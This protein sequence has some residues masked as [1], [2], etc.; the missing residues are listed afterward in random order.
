M[1][2]TKCHWNNGYYKKPWLLNY[3]AVSSISI[4][5]NISIIIIKRAEWKSLGLAK[6]QKYECSGEFCVPL[7]I[8]GKIESE[9]ISFSALDENRVE[10]EKS[11]TAVL[12]TLLHVRKNMQTAYD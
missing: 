11:E 5:I 8:Y 3:Y 2:G 10:A 12:P 6:H 4:S 1:K 9:I 7:I